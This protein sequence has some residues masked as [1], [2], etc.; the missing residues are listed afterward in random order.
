MNLRT[1]KAIKMIKVAFI[2]HLTGYG[3]FLVLLS[4]FKENKTLILSSQESIQFP[5]YSG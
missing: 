2:G 5:K 4:S 3:T 1:K